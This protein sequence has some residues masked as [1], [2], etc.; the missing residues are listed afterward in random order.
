MIELLIYSN[1][2]KSVEIADWPSGSL[3]TTATFSVECDPKRGE[4]A[5]RVT[6]NPKTGR[7]NAPKK[8]TYAKEV[9]YVDGSDGKL[10]ILELTAYGFITVMRGTFDYNYETIHQSAQSAR[11]ALIRELFKQAVTV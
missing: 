4:R 2:R 3:R 6:V 1:P 5:V 9:V 7:L 8:L 10:Y 11:Y